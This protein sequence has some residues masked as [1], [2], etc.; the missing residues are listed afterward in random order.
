MIVSPLPSPDPSDTFDEQYC[1]MKYHLDKLLSQSLVNF[2]LNIRTLCS[3][4]RS[5]VRTMR[6]LV[7]H[8][9][10]EVMAMRRLGVVSIAEIDALLERYGLHYG[11]VLE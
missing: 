8:S 7:S 5:G 10:E 6:D 4:E 3:L 9:R 2:D 11:F 1:E